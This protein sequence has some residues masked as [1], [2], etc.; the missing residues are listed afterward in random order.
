MTSERATVVHAESRAR[1][2][3]HL[4]QPL[5][6]RR[7]QIAYFEQFLGPLRDIDGKFRW[8]VH[9]RPEFWMLLQGLNRNKM[10]CEI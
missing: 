1:T 10:V 9:S 5:F 6:E 2:H 8:A 4:G 3:T 7:A